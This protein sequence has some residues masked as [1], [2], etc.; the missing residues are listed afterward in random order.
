MAAAIAP[1]RAVGI[2]VLVS[3]A[4]DCDEDFWGRTRKVRATKI[5][6]IAL[7]IADFGMAATSTANDGRSAHCLPQRRWTAVPTLSHLSN[8]NRRIR[9]RHYVKKILNCH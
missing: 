1:E 4:S 3:R 6:P 5:T 8:D 7:A 9:E 2:G